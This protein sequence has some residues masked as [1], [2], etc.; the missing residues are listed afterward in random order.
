MLHPQIN[1]TMKLKII[2]TTPLLQWFAKQGLC[3]FAMIQWC[4]YFHQNI[5]YPP[6]YI[7]VH[8]TEMSLLFILEENKFT[9][10]SIVF[11]MQDRQ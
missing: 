3:N 11:Y 8:L 10:C 9:R 5:L 4:D 1:L 2:L 6:S 7:K